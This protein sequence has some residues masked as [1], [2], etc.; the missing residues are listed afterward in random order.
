MEGGLHMPAQVELLSGSCGEQAFSFRRMDAE[1]MERVL[2]LQSRVRRLM[3][4]PTQLVG[5]TAE[6]LE[7][8]MREDL[9]LGAFVGDTLAAFSLLVINRDSM[10]R[11]LGQK[12]GFAPQECVTFDIVFVDPD[13]RGYGMQTRMLELRE[14][15]A[16]QLGAR[17]GFVTVSPE[18][19]FSLRNVCGR[20][21]RVLKRARLYGGLDRYILVKELAPEQD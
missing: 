1:D 20:G 13:Y 19:G 6:E 21:F 15:A 8:S 12:L 4:D 7:E 18:N 10:E 2:E 11:N 3:P 9:C 5:L 16:L 17:R 14:E